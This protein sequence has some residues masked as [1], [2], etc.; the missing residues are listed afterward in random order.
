MNES[1]SFDVKFLAFV[2]IDLIPYERKSAMISRYENLFSFPST[3]ARRDSL[4]KQ[5]RDITEGGI[6]GFRARLGSIH[7]ANKSSPYRRQPIL[8]KEKP[9]YDFDGGVKT[10][11]PDAIDRIDVWIGQGVDFCYYVYYFCY[12]NKDYQKIN[13]DIYIHSDDFIS[14]YTKWGVGSKPQGPKSDPTLK[15]Y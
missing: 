6:A 10:N 11:L 9:I 5:I 15:K 4:E 8:L 14:Y 1:E 7:N 2:L 12:V 3:S 13:R